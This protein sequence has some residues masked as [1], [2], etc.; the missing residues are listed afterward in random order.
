MRSRESRRSV[1]LKARMR[2]GR[3]WSDVTIANVSSRGMLLKCDTPPPAGTYIEICGPATAL[4]ARAVWV[5]GNYIGVRIQDRIDIDSMV[6]GGRWRP[7]NPPSPQP[8]ARPT[9]AA[10]HDASRQ[11][12]ASL[13]Y[14]MAVVGAV[15]MATAIALVLHG[16]LQQ[17]LR[18]IAASLG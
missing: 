11:L 5:E 10:R 12:G 1:R 14:G 9:A 6:G 7:Q 15:A 2:L 16:L 18:A 4:A 3:D 17:P 13:Q 8:A